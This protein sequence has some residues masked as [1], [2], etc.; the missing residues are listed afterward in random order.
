MFFYVFGGAVHIPG[1][2]YVDYLIP[3]MV[4]LSPLGRPSSAELGGGPLSLQMRPIAG[5]ADATPP[6]LRR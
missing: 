4:V 1:Q 3:T 5:T 6:H 2:T